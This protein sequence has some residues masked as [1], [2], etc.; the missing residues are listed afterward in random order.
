MNK[1]ELHNFVLRAGFS[2]QL[3]DRVLAKSGSE[4]LAGPKNLADSIA[5]LLPNLGN[6]MTTTDLLKRDAF[7]RATRPPLVRP[8]G[9][10]ILEQ[11]T[12][13]TAIPV[14][15]GSTGGLNF[16]EVLETVVC[17]EA[18]RDTGASATVLFDTSGHDTLT[19]ESDTANFFYWY[20]LGSGKDY[21]DFCL[22]LGSTEKDQRLSAAKRLLGKTRVNFVDSTQVNT[23][24]GQLFNPF[25]VCVLARCVGTD[26]VIFKGQRASQVLS[27]G[28]DG[29][30][31]PI[32][33]REDLGGFTHYAREAILAQQSDGVVGL[34]LK[35]TPKA[36]IYGTL[37][38]NTALLGQ[39]PEGGAML[40]P[41]TRH[42]IQTPPAIKEGRGDPVDVR[43]LAFL[44]QRE[45]S[46]MSDLIKEFN[47]SCQVLTPE[48]AIETG[49]KD[50]R[51]NIFDF[52]RL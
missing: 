20:D 35:L 51:Y 21:T 16:A 52:F 13:S 34:P 50:K 40:F 37:E 39:R 27:G 48:E 36:N 8:S 18:L 17:A 45:P 22:S 31:E 33:S 15:Y 23:A 12:R 30:L 7:V 38:I 6:N 26:P 28:F 41:I 32:G 9:N 46:G 1:K 3:A 29:L 47:T 19:G 11:I 24:M 42:R 43:I 14:M 44:A 10:R 2:P 49:T 25:H 5:R 4:I